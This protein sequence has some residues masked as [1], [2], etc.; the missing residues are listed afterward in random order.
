MIKNKIKDKKDRKVYGLKQKKPYKLQLNHKPIEREIGIELKNIPGLK[1]FSPKIA[2]LQDS[3]KFKDG[4]LE[5]K[6]TKEF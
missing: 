1:N 4:V 2:K 5:N 3:T 6:K